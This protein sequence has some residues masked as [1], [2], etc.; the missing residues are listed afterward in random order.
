MR[1]DR[2]SGSKVSNFMRFQPFYSATEK[3]YSKFCEEFENRGSPLIRI[4][5]THNELIFPV[6]QD[7][8]EAT[9]ARIPSDYV[10]G[11]KAILVP[12]GSKKQIKV[13]KGLYRFGE[14]W[15]ECIFLHPYPKVDMT[16][17]FSK[18]PNPKVIQEYQRAGATVAQKGTG[19]EILFDDNS[20]R[21][22]YLRDVLMHEIGHHNDD[23][24]GRPRRKREGFAEWFA[25][26]Y[27]Y[28]LW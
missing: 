2:Y 14:Y 3:I 24:R 22:F 6:T 18:K 28:R 20:L 17:T 27:G 13:S 21:Q 1:G 12:S 5:P 23:R 16:L 4:E 9:L 25:S 11:I 26:E 19:I 8:I 15:Q 10:D 7:D